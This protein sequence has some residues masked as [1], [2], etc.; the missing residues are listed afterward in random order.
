[1]LSEEDYNNLIKG[2]D[3]KEVLEIMAKK[4]GFISMPPTIDEFL[5]SEEY[6]G[7]IINI[8]PFW[9]EVLRKVHPSP[10]Y[11]PYR[12]LALSGSTGGGK[13]LTLD[14]DIVTPYGLVKAKDIK[15]GDYIISIDGEQTQVKGVYPQGL[16]E[17]YEIKFHDG[18]SVICD[19]DHL[20]LGWWSGTSPKRRNK[21]MS[22]IWYNEK[23]RVFSTKEIIEKQIIYD[24]NK[25]SHHFFIPLTQPVQFVNS[26]GAIDPYLIGL[27]LG[28]GSSSQTGK[29]AHS[30][31]VSITSADKE[32]EDYLK[33]F[34]VRAYPR[35]GTPAVNYV[36]T[37]HHRQKLIK[38]LKQTNLFG[39]TCK[40]KFIPKQCLLANVADRW[41][42]LQGLIDT[43]GYA[44]PK[45]SLY[46]TTISQQLANDVKFLVESLGGWAQITD[47]FPTYVYKDQKYI[48]QRAYTLYIQLP[49]KRK[50]CRLTRKI[51]NL[52]GSDYDK[53]RINAQLFRK[54]MS[55]TS[56]GLKETVCFR[57][58][59]PSRCYLTNS[60]IVTHNT[61]FCLI[62]MLYE[63]CVFLHR[64]DP[65]QAF[66]FK[67]GQ[68]IYVA[69]CNATMRL[70]EDVQLQDF[71][72]MLDNSPFFQKQRSLVAA[73][74][75][76]STKSVALNLPYNIEML[77][78]SR[79]RHAIGR[80][81]IS[82]MISELNM[83]TQE[84]GKQAINTYI[85][86][87]N[88][89]F[90]RFGREEG[91]S[92]P[93][94]LYLDSSKKEAQGVLDQ[95]IQALRKDEKVLIIEA[96]YW[97]FVKGGKKDIF[98]G[99]K[100]PVFRGSQAR[101]PFIIRTTPE[102]E[103]ISD[104]L[105]VWVPEELREFFETDPINALRDLGGI[106]TWTTG[107]FISSIE[108]INDACNNQNAM[109][110][111]GD[112]PQYREILSIDQF[113][114]TDALINYIDIDKMIKGV[115]YFAHC[116]LGLTND[117]VG[118]AF[119]RIVGK[120]NIKRFDVE[121]GLA[122]I[123]QDNV[124]STDLLICLENKPSQQVPLY[125]IEAFFVALQNR[126]IDIRGISFDQAFSADMMQRLQKL[127]FNVEYISVD[128]TRMPYDT[129]RQIMYDRRIKLPNHKVLIKEFKELIDLGDKIDHPEQT[130]LNRS[131]DAMPSKDCTDAVAGSVWN[132]AQHSDM[133]KNISAMENYIEYLDEMED[134]PFNLQDE[135][136]NMAQDLDKSG[137]YW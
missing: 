113:N 112:P 37:G 55:I 67:K 77:A 49:D 51:N 120:T 28:D 90:T 34:N 40:Y 119:T 114:D 7:G 30:G 79:A 14:S 106:S 78:G 110:Y 3:P 116:D 38:W 135:L 59:H 72:N 118:I 13:G 104:S 98:K 85:E 33:Y 43:D 100:F 75:K 81:V 27:Y 20:W 66:G 73:K 130:A 76:L 109:P 22:D 87:K 101:D 53:G 125:K 18:S 124:Y 50:A 52:K 88:R 19:E 133:G 36:F 41:S 137:G 39:K 70:A 11:S 103:G 5:D 94:R 71:F 6:L 25:R 127:G 62:S 44:A 9:R 129:L 32:I 4:A 16:K 122:R 89:L 92:P 68:P 61:S 128:R 86:L 12:E 46:Y 29:G 111:W 65:H 93:G 132:C 107:T 45:G 47:K 23:Q 83:Q 15:L 84:G 58:D 69:L 74:K 17:C 115:P 95:Y 63:I 2:K 134:R 35:L 60:F 8:Y 10:F 131:R 121:L 31:S 105:V 136:N 26:N 123:L 80:A 56:V 48:G 108:V 24:L 97:D 64:K 102:Q 117:R 1:M 57:V 126:G 82:A 54:M 91:L 99:E 21:I 96:A 42:L